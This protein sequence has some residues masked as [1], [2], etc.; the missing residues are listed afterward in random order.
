MSYVFPEKYAAYAEHTF[1]ASLGILAEVGVVVID[2]AGD[3]V[4]TGDFLKVPKIDEISDPQRRD[5]TTTGATR[6]YTEMAS[7]EETGVILHDDIA[8][9]FPIGNIAFAGVDFEKSWAMQAGFKAARRVKQSLYRVAK[10][11]IE[12]AQTSDGAAAKVDANI[13]DVYSPTVNNTMTYTRLHDARAKLGDAAGLL[14][15]AVMHSTCWSNLV[16]DGIGNYKVDS[17]AGRLLNSGGV[18]ANSLL[19]RVI[20]QNWS[21]QIATL[22]AL[23][24]TII[25]DDDLTSEA[26]TATTYVYD[27]RF[28]SLLFGPGAMLVSYQRGFT[29][30][31]ID[32]P[33]DARGV[34]KKLRLEFDYCP[35]LWGIKYT[36]ATKN[37]TDAQVATR[38]NWD[39]AY[40]NHQAV[41]CVKLITNG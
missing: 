40:Q 17:V 3:L 27:D 19:G 41:L 5:I 9:K 20:Q 36:S 38:S 22:E 26:M 10:A 13:S 8:D 18:S 32:D 35:H 11:A 14:N 34:V 4:G 25:I 1:L 6:T 33:D 37:P 21:M 23:G 2:R 31:G 12:A 15:V 7:S 39:E 24:M 16:K 28:S 30:F 29:P